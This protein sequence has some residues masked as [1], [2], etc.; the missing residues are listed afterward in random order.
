MKLGIELRYLACINCPNELVVGLVPMILQVFET[1]DSDALIIDFGL[2][3]VEGDQIGL[4]ISHLAKG[5]VKPNGR[6]VR[7]AVW[8][9][10][11]ETI[12]AFIDPK[13]SLST[14]HASTCAIQQG[15]LV[16]LD[17]DVEKW[18]DLAGQC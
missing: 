3:A 5:I 15:E 17:D 8:R 7:I 9:T 1:K 14:M 13:G 12:M 16:V 2:D 11:G 18:R 4:D 6:I 10:D